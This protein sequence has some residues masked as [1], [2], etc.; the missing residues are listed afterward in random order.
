[1]SCLMVDLWLSGV[2]LTPGFWANFGE[3]GSGEGREFPSSYRTH[4][5]AF[6]CPSSSG[7][8]GSL[9]AAIGEL[10]PVVVLDLPAPRAGLGALQLAVPCCGAAASSG[11]R[12]TLSPAL[13]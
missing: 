7:T 10:P 6:A 13:L 9:L 1:M 4:L 2:F 3:L 5:L 12:E 8:A 11:P